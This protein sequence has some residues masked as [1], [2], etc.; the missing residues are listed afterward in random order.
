MRYILA[1]RFI[2]YDY[3]DPVHLNLYMERLLN[4]AYQRE[5]MLWSLCSIFI[6]VCQ[7]RD[8]TECAKQ[9]VGRRYAC[10]NIDKNILLLEQLLI[11]E[12]HW[13]ND[14]PYWRYYYIF[15]YRRTIPLWNAIRR[16]GS[17]TL[18][19]RYCKNIQEIN[20]MDIGE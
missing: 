2:D 17:A 14:Q 3:F 15:K 18:I 10:P 9:S 19:S 13:I 7:S 1:L 5:I 12:M 11:L 20:K 4:M 16:P 6:P 8:V